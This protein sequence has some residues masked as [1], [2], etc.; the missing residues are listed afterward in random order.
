MYTK[1]HF[2]PDDKIDPRTYSG[3]GHRLDEHTMSRQWSIKRTHGLLWS[4][5]IYAP[6][7]CREK[8]GT[9]LPIIYQNVYFI[10]NTKHA[11]LMTVTEIV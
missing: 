2:I 11:M 8:N 1:S 3:K 9:V 4:F 10:I 7:K 6:R 5:L